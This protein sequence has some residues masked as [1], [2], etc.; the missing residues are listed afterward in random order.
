VA[1]NPSA[2]LDY[3]GETYADRV[4]FTYWPRY[5]VVVTMVAN[6]NFP[7]STFPLTVLPETIDVL[8]NTGT[9]TQH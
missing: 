5:D 7:Q 9:V 4:V 6:S 8:V 3:E 1:G 2:R